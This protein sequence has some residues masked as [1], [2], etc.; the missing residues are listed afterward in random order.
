MWVRR[1]GMRTFERKGRE[2]GYRG[3][4]L[5]GRIRRLIFEIAT[6]YNVFQFSCVHGNEKDALSVFKIL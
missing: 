6:S 4:V 5:V 3:D 2:R 1:K